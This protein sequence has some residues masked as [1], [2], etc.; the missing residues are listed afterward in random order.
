MSDSF[1]RSLYLHFSCQNDVVGNSSSSV[2]LLF[3]SKHFQIVAATT[4]DINVYRL[5]STR[6]VGTKLRPLGSLSFQIWRTVVK[7]HC[8]LPLAESYV[9]ARL[10][11][12]GTL[13]RKECPPRAFKF[14]VSGFFCKKAQKS[15]L[16]IDWLVAAARTFDKVRAEMLLT[17]RTRPWTNP[18]VTKYQCSSMWIGNPHWFYIVKIF[19]CRIKLFWLQNSSCTG[20]VE[21]MITNTVQ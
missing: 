11:T 12:I 7:A 2:V 13:C 17:F 16:M 3:F 8:I 4:A 14:C 21:K 20:C 6:E 19:I 15:R 5:S 10:G 9:G 1:Y 18:M